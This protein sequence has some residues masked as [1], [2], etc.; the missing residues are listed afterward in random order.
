MMAD[1]WEDIPAPVAKAAAEQSAPTASKAG[2]DEWE[3]VTLPTAPQPTAPSAPQEQGS[4]FERLFHRAKGAAVTGMNAAGTLMTDAADAVTAGGYSAARNYI[5]RKIAPETAERTIAAEQAFNT[6]HPL[7]SGTARAVGYLAPGGAASRIAEAADAGIS[8]ASDFAP[9]FAQKFLAARP[10]QGALTG[11]LVSGAQTA[12]EDSMSGA[13]AMDTLRDAGKSAALGAGIGGAF[14]AGAAALDRGAGAVLASKGA[15]ARELLESHGVDVGLRNPGKGGVF[16]RELAGVPANDAGIGEASLRGAKIITN[17]LESRFQREHGLE[18]R[19]LPEAKK[20]A[21]QQ[22]RESIAN[23][24]D[25]AKSTADVRAR[26][27]L[28]DL[29]E[30]HRIE[31]MAPYKKLK[32]AID[33]SPAAQRPRDIT[34]IVTQ[35]Q[36]AAY[37]LETAPHIRSELE[38]ELKLLD[39]YR[40]PTTG[41]IMVPERQLN[42]L[43]RSLMRAAK[44]GQAEVA[45]EADAPLRAAAVAAKQ[46]VDE[47]PYR[48]LNDFYASGAKKLEASRKTLGLPS[49]RGPSSEAE[50]KRLAN[51]LRRSVTDPTALPPSSPVG[52]GDVRTGLADALGGREDA[53]MRIAQAQE[54]AIPE[55][56]MLGLPDKIGKRKTDLN[57]V[58]LAL[59]RQVANSNTAGAS[60]ARLAD[61]VAAH[62]DMATATELPKLAK[63]RADL[64]FHITPHHGGLMARAGGEAVGKPLA[65]WGALTHPLVAI[66]ALA[67]ENSSALIGRAGVP[68]AREIQLATRIRE[69]I[70]RGVPTSMAAQ[71]AR[72]DL[73]SQ[74]AAPP[75]WPPPL[76]AD[77]KL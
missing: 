32:A 60:Q 20:A 53:A 12:A 74:P 65:V 55:R 54:A 71:L 33:D 14:G 38:A 61:Y 77:L 2:A 42:G 36:N 64:A 3:D 40:D 72:R 5:A 23:L 48:L 45:K 47:G 11:G 15:K 28:A 18:Y 13:S 10:V 17:D 31:T 4:T 50:A 19:S 59:D 1:E 24:K 66:P 57:Q 25:E 68:I 35:M 52:M 73:E 21:A 70:A 46:M 16:D 69:Y 49:R 51:S 22:A 63:A 29:E 27:A 76:D 37:D 41:A 39:R 26:K 43:R 30:E 56:Q 6:D 58:R 9:S 8:A 62:P 44:V 75:S 34:P 67:A 7:L